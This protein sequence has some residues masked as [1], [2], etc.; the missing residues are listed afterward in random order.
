MSAG[1]RK[2]QD[3]EFLRDVTFS[4]EELRQRFPWAPGLSASRHRWFESE[5]VIDLWSRYDA[6]ERIAIYQ[7]LRLRLKLEHTI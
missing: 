6:A 2:V 3:E 4:V 7:R 5:N 1:S